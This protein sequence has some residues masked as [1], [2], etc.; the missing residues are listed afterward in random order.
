[1]S[2]PSIGDYFH[3]AYNIITPFCILKVSN[4]LCACIYYSTFPCLSF[5]DLTRSSTTVKL[6]SIANSYREKLK[7]RKNSFVTPK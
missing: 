7:L 2:K 4:M 6:Y 3:M 5:H 1:M